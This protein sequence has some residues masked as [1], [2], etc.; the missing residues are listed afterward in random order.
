MPRLTFAQIAEMTQGEVI[1]G[2][3]VVTASVVID[4]REVKPDSVFFAIKG[5]RL[6]G[7]QFLSQALATA[8]GAV[9]SQVPDP[10]PAGKGI[11]KVDDTTAALQV[12]ARSIRERQPF[13]LIAVT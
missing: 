1:Q 2:G 8:R 9:V 13:T 11:V 12:L 6:D 5:E 10:L 4:S 7:H 3:E